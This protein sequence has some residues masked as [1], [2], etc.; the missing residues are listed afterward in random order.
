[1]SKKEQQK[2]VAENTCLRA[3]LGSERR[4]NR[5]LCETNANLRI[6][7]DVADVLLSE[8][9]DAVRECQSR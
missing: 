3:A 2:L 1:M 9:M 8:A 4:R 6:E 7:R 5:E